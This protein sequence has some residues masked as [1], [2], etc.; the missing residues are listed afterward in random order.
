MKRELTVLYGQAPNLSTSF[1]TRELARHLEAWFAVRHLELPPGTPGFQTILSRVFRN[2]I[3]PAVTR[4]RIDFVLYGNDGIADLRRWRAKRILYWYDAPADWSVN[5]PASFKDRLRCKNVIEADHVFAVSA[6]QVRVANTLRGGGKGCV[7]YL[8]VGVDC[9][10]FNPE[11]V[12]REGARKRLGIH[13]D[14]VVIGY[15]GFLGRWGNRFAGEALLE[16]IALLRQENYRLL[17]IGS[18]PALQQWLAKVNEMGIGER[19]IF[20]GFIAKDEL[21][22]TIMAAD[23]CVDTLEPGFHSEARSETK[24]KQ[25]M[26]MGRACVA[27]DIG[28]NRVDL[29]TGRVGLLVEPNAAA[30]AAGIKRLIH[31][32]AA[33]AQFGSG[34]RERAVST[35]AWPILAK[36]F[37]AAVLGRA[38]I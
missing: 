4:P 20:T 17:V 28:E 15:L 12:N 10:F 22:S 26:A 35:Y 13:S 19:C 29:D 32:E 25:Y 1:Q 16:A 36:K 23:I 7:H 8:P 27:T 2:L 37:V 21:P 30:L 34:A 31:D 3:W 6:A 14:Q 33:R 38:D 18:G 24:L 9:D 5:P 11:K